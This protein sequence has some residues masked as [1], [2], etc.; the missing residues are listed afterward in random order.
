M[1]RDNESVT[2]VDAHVNAV[3]F[4]LQTPGGTSISLYEAAEIVAGARTMMVTYGPAIV[5]GR[6]EKDGATRASL[7]FFVEAERSSAL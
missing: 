4:H 2:D 5:Y 7:S 3:K 1:G 6:Y